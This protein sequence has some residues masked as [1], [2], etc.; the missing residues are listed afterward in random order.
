MAVLSQVYSLIQS[1]LCRGIS[2]IQNSYKTGPKLE[3]PDLLHSPHQ[4]SFS[5]TMMAILSQVYSLIQSWLCRGILVIQNS[6]KTGPKLENPD[7]L[8][9]PHQ[10]SFSN[11]S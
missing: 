1:W 9:S 3:N 10:L 2:V 11:F 7:L 4:L 5:N 6:Y 8:H